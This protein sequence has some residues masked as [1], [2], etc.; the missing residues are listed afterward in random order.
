M[1]FQS[2][3]RCY[4]CWD[5]LSPCVEKHK[6]N[7][8]ALYAL[9]LIWCTF[10]PLPHFSCPVPSNSMG[11]ARLTLQLKTTQRVRSESKPRDWTNKLNDLTWVPSEAESWVLLSVAEIRS[12]CHHCSY[13]HASQW[14]VKLE[15][16]WAHTFS[17]QIIPFKV[18]PTK[19]EITCFS[20][21]HCVCCVSK[22]GNNKFPYLLLAIALY[23]IRSIRCCSRLVAALELSPHF[24]KRWTK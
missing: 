17:S 12:L 22:I 9:S 4:Y 3:V 13:Y 15:R 1:A 16:S 21:F 2:L 5:Q 23:R 24:W 8:Y 20:H 6:T 7:Y 11:S 10:F 14:I 18:R 19:T